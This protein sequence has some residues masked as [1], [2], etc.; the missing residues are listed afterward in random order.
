[1]LHLKATL[2]DTLLEYLGVNAYQK[3]KDKMVKRK[4]FPKEISEVVAN[5]GRKRGGLKKMNEHFTLR[6]NNVL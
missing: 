5:W 4:I 2:E 1:M 6:R 3:S